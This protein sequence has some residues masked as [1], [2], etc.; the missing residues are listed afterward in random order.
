MNK[1]TRL[2]RDADFD[3]LSAVMLSDK[4]LERELQLLDHLKK[5]GCPI[6]QERFKTAEEYYFWVGLYK[7]KIN[8]DPNADTTD[9]LLELI[10]VDFNL[11]SKNE[12]Y[13]QRLKWK[14]YFNKDEGPVIFV[15]S[16]QIKWDKSELWIKLPEW[17][18]QEDYESWWKSLHNEL[19]K[20]S[21]HRERERVKDSFKRDFLLYQLYKTK[22]A[23]R[24]NGV[25]DS[26]YTGNL[27]FDL[28][29]Y[30]EFEKIW[31]Y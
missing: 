18:K 17:T 30:P 11:D 4:F 6:P 12:E 19:L 14:F 3:K 1:D 23:E 27:L 9:S 5:L 22:R 24:K 26:Q 31:P 25:K 21:T 2:V 13:L 29:K 16:P 15:N 28:F 8:D 20:Y 7:D 10:L